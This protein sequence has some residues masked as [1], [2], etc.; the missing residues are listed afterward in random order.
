MYNGGTDS[1]SPKASTI[2]VILVE[3]RYT[4]SL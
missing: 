3:L 1:V 2:L 4:H